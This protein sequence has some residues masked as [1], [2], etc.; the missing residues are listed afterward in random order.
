[1]NAEVIRLDNLLAE[2]KYAFHA[3]QF[4]KAALLLA[5]AHILA[6]NAVQVEELVTNEKATDSAVA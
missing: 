4:R 1:M 3:G 2:A 5:E 6:V